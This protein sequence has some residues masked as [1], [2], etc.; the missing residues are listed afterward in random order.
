MKLKKQYDKETVWG[1]KL[2]LLVMIVFAAFVAFVI[3]L[4]GETGKVWANRK[5]L[6]PALDEW[7]LCLRLQYRT[8]NKRFIAAY[9]ALMGG[10]EVV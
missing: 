5:N 7:V 2:L 1:K 3:T 10:R 9:Y 6:K 8:E 4:M